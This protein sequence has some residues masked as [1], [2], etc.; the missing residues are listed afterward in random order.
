MTVETWLDTVD[1]TPNVCIFWGKSSTKVRPSTAAV[2]TDLP[3]PEF[4]RSQWDYGASKWVDV[5][6]V[7]PTMHTPEDVFAA[8]TDAE[9]D[10]VL[11]SQDANVR[12]VVLKLQTRSTPFRA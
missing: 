11:A 1:G 8:F 12:R 7:P 3:P 2:L 5:T 4:T 10:A 6:P 9:I